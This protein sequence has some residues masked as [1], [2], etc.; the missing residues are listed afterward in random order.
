MIC[1]I[2]RRF[3]LRN[4]LWKPHVVQSIPILQGYIPCLTPP[5]RTVRVRI[6]GDRAFLTVKGEAALHT[7][8]RNEFEYE[9]PPSDAHAM[10]RELC[11]PSP[12][13]KIRHIV[14]VQGNASLRWEIDVFSGNNEGLALAEIELPDE[15]ALPVLPPWIGTEITSDHRYSNSA[16]SVHPFRFWSRS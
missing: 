14:P 5:R 12:V 11:A 9:I 1:E 6:A 2:E 7:I 10:L 15:H 13:E 3:L 16:L 4:E 8:A